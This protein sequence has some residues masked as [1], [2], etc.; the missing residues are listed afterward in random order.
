MQDRLR[1]WGRVLGLVLA[2]WLAWAGG[3]GRAL[4]MAPPSPLPPGAERWTLRGVKTDRKVVA[5][6]FDI[7]WGTV[8][9]PKVFAILERE[10][11]PAT[12]FV[13]GPWAGR[14]GADLVR[15][16]AAAGMEVE[17]HGWAHVNYTGLSDQGVQDNIRRAGAVIRQLTGRDPRFVRPPNGDFSPRTLAA[18]RAVGYT[19]V[20]WGTDSLDWMNPG[21]DTIIRR[22]VT[23]VHPGDIVLLHASDTCK[24]TDLA[25]PAIIRDLRARGYQLVTLEQLLQTGTPDFRD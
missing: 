19:T 17:S 25:L 14:Q 7:S 21:V 22:V 8:M 20:T 3:W 5:L 2:V 24:Q 16:M 15:R 13:S 10:H 6:T 4:A 11:V 9:P 12:M 18:A 23:R 1:P